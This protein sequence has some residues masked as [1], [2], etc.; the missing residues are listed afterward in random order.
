[1]DLPDNMHCKPSMPPAKGRCTQRS[2][3]PNRFST[4]TNVQD[5]ELLTGQEPLG[6][7]KD[8]YN[9]MHIK[10]NNARPG[11]GPIVEWAIATQDK[12]ISVDVIE[13]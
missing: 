6:T 1:M 2:W 12:T 9:R 13:R 3:R 10:I 7:N 8:W 4:A 5:G 11:A